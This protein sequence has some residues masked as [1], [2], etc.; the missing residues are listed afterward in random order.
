MP[1]PIEKFLMLMISIVFGVIATVIWLNADKIKNNHYG[2]L[3]LL[4]YIFCVIICF[5]AL[6]HVIE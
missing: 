2:F 3:G 1:I 6:S 5:S 4:G